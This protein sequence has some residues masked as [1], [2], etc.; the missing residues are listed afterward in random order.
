VKKL[1]TLLKPGG[2]LTLFIS[3]RETFYVVGN[4]KWPALYLT[5]E[6]V[7]EALTD[8]GIVVLT[9]ERDVAPMYQIQNPIISDYKAVLFVVAQ[10]VE[11]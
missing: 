7:K 10:R 6:K 5:L 4:K 3:E 11:F 2:F 1:V 9:A 8:A